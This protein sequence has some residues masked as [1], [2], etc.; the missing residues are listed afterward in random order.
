MSGKIDQKPGFRWR[1]WAAMGILLPALQSH[2]MATEIVE[3]NITYD[4]FDALVEYQD[5]SGQEAERP[6][7]EELVPVLET[8]ITHYEAEKR[9]LEN[10]AAGLDDELD[11][12]PRIGKMTGHIE[13]F[14]KE[15]QYRRAV[16]EYRQLQEK[17]RS[18]IEE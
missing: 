10:L 9:K 3:I 11:L 12:T 4:L 18:L 5:L 15:L 17:Q 13:H 16:L 8:I 2:G 14:R 7:D 6:V 1:Q